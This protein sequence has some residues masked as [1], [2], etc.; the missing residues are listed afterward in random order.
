MDEKQK[1]LLIIWAGVLLPI[2]ILAVL[3]AVFKSKPSGFGSDEEEGQPTGQQASGE[4]AGM[5]AGGPP[6]MGGGPSPMAGGGMQPGVA[7]SGAGAGGG[8]MPGEGMMGGGMM[9]GGAPTAMPGTQQQ[10]SAAQQAIPAGPQIDEPDYV[11][12]ADPFGPVYEPKRIAMELSREVPRSPAVPEEREE[13]H[14]SGMGLPT[15]SGSWIAQGRRNLR[16]GSTVEEEERPH[17]PLEAAYRMAGILI[18]SKRVHA[19]LEAGADHGVVR[20]GDTLQLTAIPAG[21]VSG[22]REIRVVRIERRRM[23]I[24]DIDGQLKYVRL[25]GLGEQAQPT[26]T[27]TAG[28]GAPPGMMPGVMPGGM[29]PGVM[30]GGMPPGMMQGM[31]GMMGGMLPGMMEGGML[32]GMMGGAPGAGAEMGMMPGMMPEMGAMPGMPG[33]TQ[34]RGRRRRTFIRR[35]PRR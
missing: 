13:L 10:Q 27:A 12:R 20:A 22:R 33:V 9:P 4:G 8:M 31:Q 15:L 14:W 24:E 35:R 28:M 6:P 34:Q 19:I 32:P 23:L 2:L 26:P 17:E 5:Q 29:P 16:M 25:R 11:G 1:K 30:E 21:A 18:D 3:F 7:Q